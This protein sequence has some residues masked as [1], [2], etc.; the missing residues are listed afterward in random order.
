M[1]IPGTGHGDARPTDVKIDVLER[2][3]SG[4]TSDRRLFMQLLVYSGCGDTKPLVAALESRGVDAVLYADVSDPMGVGLLT[5]SEDP[6]FFVTSLRDLLT[7]EPFS[8]LRS[9]PDMAMFGRTYS[10]GF[11]PDHDDWLLERPRRTVLTRLAASSTARCFE[12]D[13]RAMSMPEH[14]SR[15]VWP[16]W[17]FSLSRS[18]LRPGSASARNTSSISGE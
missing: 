14:S 16:P 7:A 18:R 5:F 2:G 6:S 13:W 1:T 3:A 11:E 9:R 15:R 8:N 4:A 12:T 10:S 17:A